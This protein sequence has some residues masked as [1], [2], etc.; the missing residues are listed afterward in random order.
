MQKPLS[1]E[2]IRWFVHEKDRGE[3]L[4]VWHAIWADE[5]WETDES[6]YL[7]GVW[8]QDAFDRLVAF[9][10]TDV[11]VFVTG[12]DAVEQIVLTNNT[13]RMNGPEADVAWAD[14]CAAHAQAAI[15]D[16]KESDRETRQ[17]YL[18]RAAE[19]AAF[20]R[21]SEVPPSKRVRHAHW[22]VCLSARAG[23]DSP[24]QLAEI[25]WQKAERRRIHTAYALHERVNNRIAPARRPIRL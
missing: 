17:Y 20:S 23:Q 18:T 10:A 2:Q 4:A 1:I 25:K 22:A 21:S 24:L 14:R 6:V 11:C 16:L 12:E 15:D 7:L 3:A 19:L 9:A 13:T 8:N 5:F